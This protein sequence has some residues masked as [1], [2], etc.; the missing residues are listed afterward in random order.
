MEIPNAGAL[1]SCNFVTQRVTPPR[2]LLPLLDCLLS[3]FEKNIDT[4]LIVWPMVWFAPVPNEKAGK[5]LAS[6]LE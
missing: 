4:K 2:P 6:Q 5:L 3:L 1:Y